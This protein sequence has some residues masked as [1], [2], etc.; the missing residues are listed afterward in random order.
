[1]NLLKMML[2]VSK[3]NI[4][5]IV[6]IYLNLSSIIFRIRVEDIMAKL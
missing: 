4:K 1:M 6:L 2:K 5:V 3:P